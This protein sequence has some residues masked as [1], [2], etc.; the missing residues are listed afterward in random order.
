MKQGKP[1]ITLV[2]VAIAAAL[3]IYFTFYAFHT[4]NDPFTTTLAYA[5]TSYD[6]VEADG[7]LI[8]QEQVIPAQSGIVDVT[9]GEGEKV[10]VGQEVALVYRDTQAQSDR[11]DLDALAMEIELLEFAA[12]DGGGV[13]S[14]ARLDEDILQSLVALRSSSALGDYTQLEKQVMAVKSNVL[15]RGYTYGDGL[16]SA[17]LSARLRD[18]KSQYSTLRR[19]SA[20][21]TTQVKAGQS[22]IFSALVD[23]YEGVLT[24]D[25]ARQLTPSSL[26]TMLAGG[27]ASNGGGIGKLI[28]SDRW[29]FAAALSRD[30]AERLKPGE[31]TLL[32]F[33]GDFSQDVEMQVDRIGPAE[34]DETL[35]LF[36]SDRYMARTTLLRRQTAELI[37]DSWTGLRI[38]KAALRMIKVT[39]QDSETKEQRE[40]NR[41][42]V[43]VLLGGRAEFKTAEVVTEG[44]DYYVVRPTTTDS[45][46]LRAG[47]EV[48]VQAT[49]LYDGQLLEF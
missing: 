16:T 25:A 21:A 20:A 37:F 10:G 3:A 9:R 17:D 24:P 26:K 45:S 43:Y 44:S 46:A 23:G 7:M 48:I 8:R 40:E 39:Y 4:F 34:G 29:F 31:T 42:G 11:A 33:S 28:T 47:D 30:V 13:A 19:Q 32:R 5:F 41:L 36:S 38:P 15:K 18:L 12:S 1:V 22:G 27:G 49:G 14:A 2:M 35:V 6:S